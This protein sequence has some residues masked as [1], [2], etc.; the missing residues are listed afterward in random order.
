[1]A[2][3]ILS[4]LIEDIRGTVGTHT[5]SFWKGIHLVKNRSVN[6]RTAHESGVQS[7]Y[8]KDIARLPAFWY[9]ELTALQRFEWLVYANHIATLGFPYYGD[10]VTKLVGLRQYGGI[11]SGFNAF[12]LT[13][14]L[15][16]SIGKTVILADNPIAID[17]PPKP[18]FNALE[19]ILGPPKKIRVWI[20]NPETLT[21]ASWLRIFCRGTRFAHLIIAKTVQVL[22]GAPIPWD[23]DYDCTVE[24]D[25]AVPAWTLLGNDFCTA[26]AGIITID[27]ITPGGNSAC[28]YKQVAP[29]LDNATGWAVEFRMKVVESA[30]SL[31]NL[32][33][34]VRDGTYQEIIAFSATEIKLY[35]GGGV[36]AMDTTDDYHVYRI[37][38][39]GEDVEV[40]VDG[41]LRIKKKLWFPRA[42]KWIQFGDSNIVAGFN[43]N[44]KWDYIK[45]YLAGN[46]GPDVES[47]D[48][49]IMRYAKGA[50]LSLQD[51]I[52]GVQLDYISEN[53]RYSPP[54]DIL[55]QQVYSAFPEGKWGSHFWKNY[56]WG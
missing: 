28:Y 32:A 8:Q 29:G 40:R 41:V 53:G 16:F 48:I 37:S 27:T 1:M 11:M 47:H 56:V 17:P 33:L 49:E 45:W 5:F 12:V 21:E 23:E 52:Y 13:N 10:D 7:L 36:F 54:S 15:R 6:F 31:T 51:D 26:A 24:P 42:D 14:M 35:I 19:F 39:K 43:S 44:S 55:S 9:E 3:L 30:T 50:E 2:R 4:D 46:E 22:T 34:E 38:G 18:I 20:G 25:A